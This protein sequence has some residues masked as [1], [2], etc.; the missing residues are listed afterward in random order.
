M[1][2]SALRKDRHVHT[3]DGAVE[4]P[5]EHVK[6]IEKKARKVEITQE[7]LVFG[8]SAALRIVGSSFAIA[9][10]VLARSAVRRRVMLFV[11]TTAKFR[12]ALAK[13]WCAAT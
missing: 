12:G 2:E 8:L 3:E 13:F 6:A 5:P 4:V 1:L 7:E 10:F 11:D 9:A